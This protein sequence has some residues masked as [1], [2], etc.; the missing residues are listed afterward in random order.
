MDAWSVVGGLAGGLAGGAII[1]L[2][3]YIALR[4][5]KEA[6]ESS[7]FMTKIRVN[8]LFVLLLAYASILLVFFCLLQAGMNPKDA[9]DLIS[10]PL[11]ALIGGTLA[12]AKDLVE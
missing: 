12:V 6:G 3:G 10:V 7:G 9:Y 5:N 2:G 4:R 8:V 11:V 1:A